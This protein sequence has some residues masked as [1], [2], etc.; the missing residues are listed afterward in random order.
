MPSASCAT[1]RRSPA[2][3]EY[4]N[5]VITF[6]E[7]H[8]D[9]LLQ[10]ARGLRHQGQQRRGQGEGRHARVPH[11][12]LKDVLF[13]LTF[14][15]LGIFKLTPEK[16]EAGTREHP[17]RQG[18]DV[19]RA[20][21][22]QVRRRRGLGRK[23]SC[24]GGRESVPV[25]G[26]DSATM[27]FQTEYPFTLPKGFVDSEGNLHRHGVMR[28]ATAKDEIVPLQDY[29]VQ[30]QSRVPRHHPACARDHQARRHQVHRHRHHREPVLDRPR[31]SAG[32]LPADQRG[33]RAE[34]PRQCPRARRVRRRPARR[35]DGGAVGPG[36]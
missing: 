2:S 15:H 21:Q 13:T 9:E 32:V 11:R 8:A 1:I 3:I 31:V 18:R 23:A 30:S 7:S 19:L 10:V 33:G 26:E 25:A 22:V 17:P 35:R 24:D 28:L 12:R 16:V 29:R 36:G 4:P 6:A 34:G 27:A 14:Q 5:L 20:H